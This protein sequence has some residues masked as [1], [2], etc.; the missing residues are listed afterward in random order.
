MRHDATRDWSALGESGM[1]RA[2]GVARATWLPVLLAGTP[3]CYVYQCIAASCAGTLS[4][5][6]G[7][8]HGCTYSLMILPCSTCHRAM[9]Y[10]T[11][12]T[13]LFCPMG[14][15]RPIY[16]CYIVL[17]EATSQWLPMCGVLTGAPRIGRA[18][19]PDPCGFVPNLCD[20]HGPRDPRGI[21]WDPR[22]GDFILRA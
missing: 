16:L 11:C 3:S 5:V 6:G 21:Q 1:D 10:P 18:V 22:L 14:I 4:G 9:R 13:R 20:E 7:G 15:V 8:R 19:S 17:I 12:S 2:S